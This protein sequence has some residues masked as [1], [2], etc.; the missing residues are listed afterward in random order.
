M[1]A[2]AGFN[3]N[4]LPAIGGLPTIGGTAGLPALGAHKPKSTGLALFD[5]IEINENDDN[6]VN[7]EKEQRKALKKAKQDLIAQRS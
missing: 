1:G 5:E 2:A 4:A 6:E 3:S 7:E